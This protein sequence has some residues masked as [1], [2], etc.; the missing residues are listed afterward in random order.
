MSFTNPIGIHAL[1]WAGDTSPESVTRAITQTK[2]TG[3]DLLEFSLHDSLNLDVE[4]TRRQLTE[5][6]LGVACSRGL[7][8]AADVS[9]ED[10]ETVKL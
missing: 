4:A 9:S 6:G 1:V 10:P 7:S 5:A 8:F 3:Y 2:K